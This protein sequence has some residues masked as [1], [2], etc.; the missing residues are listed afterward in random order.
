[1]MKRFLTSIAM[2]L[3]LALGLSGVVAATEGHGKDGDDKP[4]KGQ[5]QKNDKKND[6]SEEQDD[7]DA[8]AAPIV[9]LVGL[10]VALGRSSVADDEE[11]ILGEPVTAVVGDEVEF[12]GSGPFIIDVSDASISMAWNTEDPQ[13]DELERVLEEGTADVYTLTFDDPVLGG[14]GAA[15]HEEAVLQPDLSVISET[16]LRIELGSGMQVGDGLDALIELGPALPAAGEFTKVSIN[17]STKEEMVAALEA[18]GVPGATAWANE[19]IGH[20]PFPE[21]DTSFDKLLDD[22]APHDPDPEVVDIILTILEP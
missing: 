12:P 11:T 22:V 7:H 19:I 18:A 17:D 21:D 9:S 5:K 10:T 13:W 16:E 3:A 15:S 8:M 20:R 1:M 4:K 2:A 14:L 6:K